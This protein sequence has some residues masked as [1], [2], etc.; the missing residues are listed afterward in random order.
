VFVR[1]ELNIIARTS[2]AIYVSVAA[3]EWKDYLVEI[4]LDQSSERCR[5]IKA[6]DT[7]IGLSNTCDKLRVLPDSLEIVPPTGT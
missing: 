5:N 4:P 1:T 7:L 2:E 6:G 3:S